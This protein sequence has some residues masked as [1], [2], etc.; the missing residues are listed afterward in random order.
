MTRHV[1]FWFLPVNLLIF[2]I[3]M[4]N[5]LPYPLISPRDHRNRYIKGI[6]LFFC[7][8]FLAAAFFVALILFAKSNQDP[9]FLDFL[10]FAD[11]NY[12]YDRQIDLI[13]KVEYPN[14]KS[15]TY[16]DYAAAGIPSSAHADFIQQKLMSS[17]FP[18]PHS[19]SSEKY[20]ETRDFILSLFNARDQYNIVF[21]SGATQAIDLVG[22]SLSWSNYSLFLYSTDNHIS[23]LG[24]REYL[25]KSQW[26]SVD[27]DDLLATALAHN[28]WLSQQP[29]DTSS[30][31]NLLAFPAQSNF[32]GVLY[33]YTFLMSEINNDA[34][35]KGLSDW[36]LLYDAASFVTSHH[37]D[38][39]V[40]DSP[41][42]VPISFYKMIGYPTGI[43]ALIIKKSLIEDF[44]RD[45]FGGG[46]VVLALPE[47]DVFIRKGN[48]EERI[49][50]GSIS[51]IDILLLENG[52][53]LREILGIG[54]IDKHTTSL[55]QWLVKQLRNLTHSNGE[56]M[57]VL[58]GNHQEVEDKVVI[59]GNTN[60]P[61]ITFTLM[62]NDG[63]PIHQSKVQSHAQ[64]SSIY[65]RT[66]ALCN[67]GAF[68]RAVDVPEKE[69]HD[70]FVE[71]CSCD[72]GRCWKV[73]EFET[74]SKYFNVSNK[75]WPDYYKDF[76]PTGTVRVSLGIVSSFSDIQ[77]FLKFV[78]QFQN[79]SSSHF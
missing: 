16:M 63:K 76:K 61:I 47:H 4:T 28:L 21:T 9:D 34:R 32:H 29:T 24:I 60:G 6:T 69:M 71:G 10:Y 75:C 40:E 53:T 64:K 3:P 72:E 31:V 30:T 49:E 50:V 78:R 26:K 22:L 11:G 19:A 52:F 33:P 48:H 13:R 41:S 27:Y 20:Q 17:V 2:P 39:G 44:S 70:R 7:F 46:S 54:A 45:Y 14:L 1:I 58:Y 25:P 74:V 56:K 36:L 57:V 51:F 15:V 77:K 55:T 23:V 59:E 65:V 35:S 18:N 43:G 38:L 8:I 79:K 66:G 12:G 62:G 68:A 37:L 67:H 42:F 73:P 5:L